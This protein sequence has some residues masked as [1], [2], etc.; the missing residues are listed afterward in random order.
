MKLF[1]VF[2]LVGIGLVTLSTIYRL[3]RF[4]KHRWRR[5][6]VLFALALTAILVIFPDFTSL[7][8]HAMGIGR[9]ADLMLYLTALFTLAGF[10][11]IYVRLQ[12][13]N[14]QMTLVVRHLALSNVRLLDSPRELT[15]SS[16]CT[17]EKQ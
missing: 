5:I 9:G 1:Q 14:R 12:R 2:I 11:L 4:R 15:D 10:F 13:V 7:T 3:I 17:I 16:E 6:T 8:A